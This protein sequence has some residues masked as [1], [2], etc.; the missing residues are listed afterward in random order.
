[1]KTDVA[2]RA[3]DITLRPARYEDATFVA[4][5]LTAVFPDDPVD[6]V[7]QEHWWRNP[8]SNTTI[9]RYIGELAGAPVAFAQMRHVA[10]ER[11]PQRYASVGAD[12]LPAQRTA[13]RLDALFAAMEDRAREDGARTVTFW[14]WDHDAARIAVVTKRGYREERRQRFWQLDLAANRAKIEAMAAESRAKMRAAGIRVLTIDRD[15]DPEKFQ[16]LWR[17]SEEAI[18]DIPTTVPYTGTSFEDFM[19]WMRSP[20]V[21]DDRIW[22]ARKG[23]DVLGVSMLNYPPK[24]GVVSTDWTGVGRAG[25]GHG[26]ARALKC[27]TVMQAIALGVDRVRTD[28][29][30]KNAPILHINET[31]GYRIRAEMIQFMRSA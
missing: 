26:V 8:D 9:E 19:T 22:I 16:K 5:L 15:D 20:G 17:M 7:Q 31:M 21:R 11:M 12:V 1:M 24:R 14:T 28:N 4:D 29:D 6:P 27:E 30:S 10:W 18:Y 2:L 3:A 13:E 25:R 23:D